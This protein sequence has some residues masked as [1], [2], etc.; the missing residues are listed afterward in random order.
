MSLVSLGVIALV[1]FVSPVAPNIIS[2]ELADGS[3]VVDIFRKLNIIEFIK[4]KIYG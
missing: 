4:G 2:P 1:E 3:M